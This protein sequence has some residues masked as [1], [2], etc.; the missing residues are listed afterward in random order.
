M[1]DIVNILT[2]RIYF[3]VLQV[4]HALKYRH[5]YRKFELNMKLL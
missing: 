2:K 5:I 3:L 4:K 1:S